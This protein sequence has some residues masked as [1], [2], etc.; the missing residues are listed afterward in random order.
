MT[1][2]YAPP[3]EKLYRLRI[4]DFI[5]N[6]GN[7]FYS[8]LGAGVFLLEASKQIYA[9][10]APP[11][12]SLASRPIRVLKELSDPKPASKT[13]RNELS[14]PKAVNGRSILHLST[15]Y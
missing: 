13:Y 8:R 1:A 14:N 6:L 10:N 12:G 9:V 2:L 7:K 5:E 3:I 4:A 11:L 15:K